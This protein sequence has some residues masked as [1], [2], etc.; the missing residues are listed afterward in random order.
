MTTD[1]LEAAKD[2]ILMKL[3]KSNPEGATAHALIDIAE[4]LRV[5]ADASKPS[6]I[7]EILVGY[8][9]VAFDADS[10]PE[11]HSYL[12]ST[13]VEADKARRAWNPYAS[14]VEVRGIKTLRPES[15]CPTC[16]E[17]APNA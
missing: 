8:G 17:E 4:S 11:M 9:V 13:K 2:A 14:L 10:K 7:G 3:G 15:E 5:I 12:W 1:H 6:P 16:T